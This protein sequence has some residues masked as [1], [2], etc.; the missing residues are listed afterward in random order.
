MGS[1]A[2]G[3][4]HRAAEIWRPERLEQAAVDELA[5]HGGSRADLIRLREYF[6]KRAQE[7]YQDVFISADT[8]AQ[9]DQFSRPKR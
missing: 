8:G 9:T 1:D 5:C 4:I 7:K 6:R 2:N 3:A